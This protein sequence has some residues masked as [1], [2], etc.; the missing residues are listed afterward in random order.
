MLALI[1]TGGL[2]A[3]LAWGWFARKYYD[4]SSYVCMNCGLGK[5]EYACKFD[6]VT[7]QNRRG[8]TYRYKRTFEDTAI[9]LVLQ[10]TNCPHAWFLYRFGRGSGFLLRGFTAHADGGTRANMI[11]LLLRDDAFA[12]DLAAMSGASTVWSNLLIAVDTR[13]AIN[14]SLESWWLNALDRSC[15]S[16]WWNQALNA[17]P[18]NGPPTIY[19]R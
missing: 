19:I 2:V 6:L 15:F 14:E 10:A 9:S 5:T 11:P 12:K 18:D 13:P 3:F 7:W 1:V 17:K 4:N 8:I 16:N